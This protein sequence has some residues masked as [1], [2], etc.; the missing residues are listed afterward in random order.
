V[1]ILAKNT[2][3]ESAMSDLDQST[4]PDANTGTDTNPV[5]EA[6]SA[7]SRENGQK[8]HGP[9]SPEGKA[10]SRFNAVKCNL[11]GNY[12]L[13]TAEDAPRYHTHISDYQSQF[14]PIGPE[15]CALVQSIADI[16]WRLNK[17]PG[18]EQVILTIEGAKITA[19]DPTYADPAAHLA[20]EREVRLRHEKELRNLALQEHR[21]SR[22]REREA[23]ELERL[24]IDRK[25]KQEEAALAAAA[26]ASLL[27]EH[28]KETLT[29]VPGLGFV[30]SKLRFTTYM[31]RLTPAEKAKLLSEAIA[32]SA[33]VPQSREA[34]A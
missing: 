25:V 16:R 14:Q 17:I 1:R 11:T 32:E 29:N 8:S 30:F 26:K 24:Q 13:V 33:E 23:A 34:A 18:L 22:R 6:R 12:V 9:V 10:K 3:E 4:T 19:E 20:L 21:L 7:A 31:T 5:S 28:R 15:E 2:T 27:A